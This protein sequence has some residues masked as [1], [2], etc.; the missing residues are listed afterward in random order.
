MRRIYT[1][2]YGKR[3]ISEFLSL[4]KKYAV[5]VIV[6]VRSFPYSKQ[7]PDFS[8]ERLKELLN[9]E[10]IKF[11]YLGDLLGGRPKDADC[12]IDG[13][14]NYQKCEEKDFFKKGIARLIAGINKG[15]RICLM[16][17]EIKPEDCHRSKLIGQYLEKMNIEVLHIDEGGNIKT[18]SE[19][20]EKIVGRQKTLFGDFVTS[21]KRY[22]RNYK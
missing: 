14:V 6:D 18:Q 19:V 4:L 10:N 12:Y 21:K 9:K 20:W 8:K 2:G 15:Y 22:P 5:E 7:N 16:C 17:S 3:N 11:L 1:I 13:K